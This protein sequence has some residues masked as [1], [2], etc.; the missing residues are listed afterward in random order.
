M[1]AIVLPLEDDTPAM[2]GKE[3]RRSVQ[4]CN[5]GSV[6]DRFELDIVGQ[7]KSW[8]RVEPAEINVFPDQS[9]GVELI[10]TPPRT[11]DLPAGETTFALRVMSHED[12]EGSAVEEITVAV[13]PFI[14]FGVKLIP[15]IRRARIGARFNAVVDN[16][17]NVP[18]KA[19]IYASDA[20]AALH[21]D[22]AYDEIEVPYGKG[23]IVPVKARP[24]ARR[25]R[26]AE[27]T[28]P[29]QILAVHR[30]EGGDDEHTADGAVVQVALITDAAARFVLSVAAA[31]LALLALWYVVLKP[32]VE[33]EARKQ[34]A[35]ATG[36]GPGPHPQGAAAPSAGTVAG[37]GGSGDAQAGRK[38]Q[39]PS[40]ALTGGSG[41]GDRGTGGKADEG[42]RA[43]TGDEPGEAVSPT[44]DTQP[45][46][47]RLQANAAASPDFNTEARYT[48]PKGSALHVSDVVFENVGGDT[49]VVRLQRGD[50][51]LR[52][53][54]LDAF[55]DL[56]EHY[57]EPIRF[58]PGEDVV[59]AVRCQAPGGQPPRGA[60]TC[61]P[62]AY[63]S[64]RLVATEQ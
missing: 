41:S 62:A 44:D 39:D 21:F 38:V 61:T 7:A 31:L 19:Q 13:G 6:V 18:L 9:V 56:D 20:D 47:F 64:G 8:I 16:R 63:F 35:V 30:Q 26:G 14:D 49:G 2:P 52:Q 15:A 17:G 57:S 4:I 5:S 55:R 1:G 32:S 36:N 28:L 24:A 42:A 43:G 33:T 53:V 3:N 27:L 37:G 60:A 29:F 40:P 45:F 11:A 34:A 48:V 59:L 54:A 12:V 23:V 58:G 22:L 51:V 25:W 50:S 10:F 46:D